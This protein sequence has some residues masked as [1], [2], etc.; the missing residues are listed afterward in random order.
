MNYLENLLKNSGFNFYFLVVDKFLDISLPQLSN[1]YS[2]FQD[3]LK[4]KN[5]GFLLSQK[6][7]QDQIKSSLKPIIIKNIKIMIFI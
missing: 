5:S 4:I 1:F 3:N 2:L 6:N 7:T